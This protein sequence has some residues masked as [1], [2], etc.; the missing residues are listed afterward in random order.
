MRGKEMV[1]DVF[2][3][4]DSIRI[5]FSST[6]ENIDDVC[7][8]TTKYLLVHVKE[9]KKQ[10]FAINLV[11][12]EG[13]TNAVRHG[14]ASDPEKIVRFMLKIDSSDLIRL[15]IEDQGNGFDWQKQKHVK[16]PDDADHGRGILIMDTY[17]SR[18]FYNEKG[19]ILYL[20]KRLT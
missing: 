19:N 4:E 18:Y 2:K 14:N 9:I 5:A 12:R 13:L 15:V 3:T 11:L 1:F 10:L 6:L 17:C 7:M 16:I 20:E 8:Q